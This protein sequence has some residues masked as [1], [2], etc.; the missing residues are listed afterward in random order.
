[1]KQNIIMDFIYE[2]TFGNIN[3]SLSYKITSLYKMDYLYFSVFITIFYK[4]CE[5]IKPFKNFVVIN[6]AIYQLILAIA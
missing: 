1:M 6:I 5:E 4:E 3:F 2:I